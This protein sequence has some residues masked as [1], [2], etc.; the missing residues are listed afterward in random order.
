MVENDSVTGSKA[1]YSEGENSSSLT[2]RT[3]ILKCTSP[4]ETVVAGLSIETEIV[5]GDC[6][7]RCEN[8]SLH[9]CLLERD[10]LVSHGCVVEQGASMGQFLS[11]INI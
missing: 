1:I 2:G 10:H 8:S 5:V 11:L 7:E 6:C 9:V 4:D 3:S